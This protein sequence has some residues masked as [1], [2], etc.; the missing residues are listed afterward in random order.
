MSTIGDK[1]TFYEP[2]SL[3]VSNSQ[4]QAVNTS[5]DSLISLSLEI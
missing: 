1:F 2:D 5:S 3:C 4:L